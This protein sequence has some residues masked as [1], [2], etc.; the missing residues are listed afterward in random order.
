[1]GFA[2][3]AGVGDVAM[4]IGYEQ[5]VLAWANEQARLIRA[6]EFD[7]LDIEHI[8]DEIEDVGKSEKRELA[9]RMAVLLA[10]LLKWKFQPARQSKSWERTVKEQ[11]KSLALHLDEVPSLKATL[12]DPR[13]LGAV[14]ADAVAKAIEDTG[15]E[16]FPDACPWTVEDI[17]RDGWL[18]PS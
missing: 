12:R 15:S 2:R 8:A 11:R 10:H 14:W 3:V 13:W 7:K 4:P 6:G 5:D 17:L 18:P 1:M 9:S 16:D